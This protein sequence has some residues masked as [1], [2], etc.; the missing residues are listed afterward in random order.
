MDQK[1][2]INLGRARVVAN[3]KNESKVDIFLVFAFGLVVGTAIASQYAA[4]VWGLA[5]IIYVPCIFLFVLWLVQSRSRKLRA[6]RQAV[7]ETENASLR[8]AE[9]EARLIKARADG[10]LDRWKKL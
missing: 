4:Y 2:K 5:A 9:T 3:N 7:H 1:T 10:F 8:A 6:E